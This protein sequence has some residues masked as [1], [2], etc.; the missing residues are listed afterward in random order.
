MKNKK[1][2][3]I[4]FEDFVKEMLE[5]SQSP[6]LYEQAIRDEEEINTLSSETLRQYINY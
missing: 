1:S 4:D 2:N 3:C 5:K 6:K